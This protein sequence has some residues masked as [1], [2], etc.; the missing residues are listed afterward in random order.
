[1]DEAWKKKRSGIFLVFIFQYFISAAESSVNVASLWV[2]VTTIMNIENPGLYYGLINASVFMPAILFSTILARWAD[3]T[4]RIKIWLIIFNYFSMIGSILYII[5]FSPIYA[6]TGKFFQG[7]TLC[8]RPLMIGEIA[9]SYLHDELQ[10]KTPILHASY[11]LGFSISPAIT[12]LFVNTDFWIGSIHITYGNVSGLFVLAMTVIL[13]IVVVFSAHDVSREFDLKEDYEQR[14]RE[15]EENCEYPKNVAAT[16]SWMDTL[17]NVFLK[18]DTCLLMILSIYTCYLDIALFRMLPVIIIHNLKY[19]YAVVNFAFIGFAIVNITLTFTIIR[20]KVNSTGVY[21]FGL[22]SLL[23]LIAISGTIYIFSEALHNAWIN[24][25]SLV[26]FIVALGLF[27]LGEAIFIQV[28]CAKLTRSC[29]Q[30]YVE[31]I[32]VFIKQIGEIIG[33]LTAVYVL[34]E[35][36]YF[37]VFLII[38][39]LAMQ[40][41][42][43]LRKKTLINPLPII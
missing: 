4:R 27:M 35:G 2:Y 3:K 24:I 14:K 10:Y 11:S 29:H 25:M 37:C 20:Y 40:L 9:R 31:S 36:V 43:I 15:I 42:L 19:H 5:P 32:R 41:V 8:L 13:Q 18:F 7:F 30:S 16:T 39:S 23:S 1:M 38:T 34:E 12:A 26:I 6:L 17:R 28:V 33:A 21:Y 22:L